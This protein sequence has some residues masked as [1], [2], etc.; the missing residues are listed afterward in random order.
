MAFPTFGIW[1]RKKPE[2]IEY[3]YA[4]VENAEFSSQDFYRDIEAVVKEKRLPGLEPSR[5]EF[6]EGGLLSARR[7]YLRFRRER[8]VFDI[9][10]APFGNEWFFSCRFSEIKVSLLVWEILSILAAFWGLALFYIGLFGLFVGLAIFLLAITGLLLLLRNA[11][12]AISRDFD[13]WMLAVPV[14]GALYELVRRETY[15]RIDTRVMFLHVIDRIVRAK[16]EEVTAAKGI[17]QVKFK[18]ATPDLN[19]KLA[20]LLRHMNKLSHGL[21]R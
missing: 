8:L 20:S 2:V 3:W 9:C 7:E 19:P 17:Q 6:A 11:G 1:R 12:N 5:I 16:V 15:Y 10:S 18:D 21:D 4:P 14:L 13:A